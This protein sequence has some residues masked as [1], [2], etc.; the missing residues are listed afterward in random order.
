MIAVLILHIN[1]RLRV[2][3]IEVKSDLRKE[4][5]G[6][7][8]SCPLSPYLLCFPAHM[9]SRFASYRLCRRTPK[10]RCPDDSMTPWDP[11]RERP[12]LGFSFPW[13]SEDFMRS[14]G[15]PQIAR[16]QGQRACC[17]EFGRSS[18]PKETIAR[19]C[20]FINFCVRFFSF[21]RI[22]GIQG[23]RICCTELGRSP[24]PN[25]ARSSS[26]HGFLR[27]SLGFVDFHGF[28]GSKVKGL[29]APNYDRILSWRNLC[30]IS[31][32]VYF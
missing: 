8:Q 2:T 6:I 30:S 27:I 15:F 28:Q 7:R 32:F 23:Q 3:D 25:C 9:L 29:F 16:V 11:P 19:I 14:H 13:I 12:S 17:P 20:F 21:S 4:N 18:A 26:F 5:A 24:A 31:F 1:L 22:S 10:T